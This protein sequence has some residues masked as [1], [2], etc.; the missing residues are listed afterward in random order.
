MV[1]RESRANLVVRHDGKINQETENSCPKKVPETYRREKHHRPEMRKRRA[2]VRTLLRSKLEK[3]PGFE[4]Q[5]RQGNH[6][7]CGKERPQCHVNRGLTGE[8]NV[9][10]RPDDAARRI[11]QDVQIDYL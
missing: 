3:A 6:L 9:M 7:C 1:G 2:C 11:E 10:H 8:I 5:E 4:G